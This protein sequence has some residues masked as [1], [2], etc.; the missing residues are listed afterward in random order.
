MI[1]IAMRVL[2]ACAIL[3]LA[4]CASAPLHYYTLV[5]PAGVPTN[6]GQTAGPPFELLPVSVP[7]QVDQPQ[8]LV[9]QGGQGVALLG[10]ERWIAPLGD[11][12]RSAMSAD[13]SAELN[14][15]DVSGLPGN[16]KPRLR[17]KLDL[18]R[19]DSEPGSYALIEAA[20]SVRLLSGGDHAE[21]VACSS[22]IRETVAPGYAALV[23]GHQRALGQ[24][25]A[26]M[27]AVARSLAAG[28]PARCPTG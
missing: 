5:P 16:G 4:G 10:S 20:W 14:S 12:V 18:R 9:R 13:L 6:A 22:L 28:E 24:L 7:A 27:A 26:Q 23:Q 1:R 11:E 19:F 15:Q 8:L 21:P 2:T 25:A 17:I 3:G